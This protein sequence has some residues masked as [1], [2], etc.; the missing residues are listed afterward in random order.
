MTQFSR[1]ELDEADFRGLVAAALDRICDQLRALPEQ[2][3]CVTEGGAELARALRESLPHQPEPL[4]SLLRT[5]FERAL[6][7]SF[8]TAGP[9]YLAYIPGG[10]L[11]HAAVADLIADAINRYVGLWR[12]APGLVQLESNVIAWLAEIVGLPAG[13]GGVLTSGGSLANFSAT[14]AARHRLGER[15]TDGTIYTSTQAHHSVMRA[16]M[17]AG[18]PAAQVR[19]I[20]VDA[21]QRIRV[22][23]LAR[24][25]AED[26]AS[27]LRPCMIVG[28]AGTTNTGA[29]DDLEGLAELAAREQVWLHVDAAYGGCFALTRR[30]GEALRGLG[31]ADSVTLDPHKGLFLPYGTGALLVRDPQAL[32]RA[33]SHHAEYLPPMQDDPDFVDFC[34]L[35]PELSRDFRGLR[36]WLPLKLC[37][38][39]AF[40][41]ALDEKLDLAAHAAEVLRATPELE[42]VAEPQLSLLA[43]RHVPARLNGD[44]AAIDAHNRRLLDAVNR[45]ARVYLTSTVL[46][47]RLVLRICV[48]SFRTHR[49]RIDAGLADIHAAIA[50]LA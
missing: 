14:V 4:E 50:E 1:L 44:A 34:E 19:A 11:L 18:F 26:R 15:F 27:G 49:D 42:I 45:R 2:P 8:N 22:D 29:V 31:R 7:V 33:H 46:D 13:S 10:G 48:L 35:S 37:G 36:L 5:L 40:A 39:D 20:A 17:L 6:P 3:A 24:A 38:V 9:G 23:L 41:A 43:F 21:R 30:G 32:R 16:A 28:S 47:G 25:I 12:A